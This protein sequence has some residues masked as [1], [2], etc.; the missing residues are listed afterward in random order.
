MVSSVMVWVIVSE[1]G[2]LIV[3]NTYAVADF[4]VVPSVC[5]V[6]SSVA[7]VVPAYSPAKF[8]DSLTPASFTVTALT[9]AGMLLSVK[10]TA[11]TAYERVKG[12]SVS[13]STVP[14]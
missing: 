4:H 2:A 14:F 5:F 8:I 12:N 9:S 3:G 10:S 1:V 13:S 6:R 11:A 7:V